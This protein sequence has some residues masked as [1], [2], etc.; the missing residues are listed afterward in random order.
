MED[1][2]MDDL[3]ESLTKAGGLAGEQRTSTAEQSQVE[4]LPENLTKAGRVSG[5]LGTSTSKEPKTESQPDP[6]PT[7]CT[8]QH[9]IPSGAKKL[10]L[11]YSSMAKDAL[12][13]KDELQELLEVKHA[14][15]FA[16]HDRDYGKTDLIQF[17]ANLKER[18]GPPMAVPPYKTKP[19]VKEIID[20]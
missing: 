3:P 18:D 11:D 4:G 20:R 17:R 16:K 12:P 9:Q 19:E 13:F 10:S 5:E 2:L 15:A 8:G 7:G 1:I 14:K 6:M